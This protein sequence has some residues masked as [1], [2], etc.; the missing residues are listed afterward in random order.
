MHMLAQ[1]N[2][3]LANNRLENARILSKSVQVIDPLQYRGKGKELDMF[4][5]TQL[6]KLVFVK[7]L[8]PLAKS[9]SCKI[10]GVFSRYLEY[11]PIPVSVADRKYGHSSVG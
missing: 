2:R 7:H 4:S 6:L 3:S 8:F 5:E 10:C 9:Q 11:P 1:H